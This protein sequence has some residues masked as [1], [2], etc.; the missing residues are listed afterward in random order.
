MIILVVILW[1]ICGVLAAGGLYSYAQWDIPFT[2]MLFSPRERRANRR[3]DMAMACLFG[4][5]GPLA[6]IMAAFA[7]GFFVHGFFRSYRHRGEL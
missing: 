1:V 6:L 4:L 3:G 7:T 2:P 5:S